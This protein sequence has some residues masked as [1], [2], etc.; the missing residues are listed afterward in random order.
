[1]A[2]NA[3][4]PR[5]ILN[6]FEPWEFPSTTAAPRTFE[7][8]FMGLESNTG[9]WMVNIGGATAAHPAHFTDY[10]INRY[11]LEERF[12]QRPLLAIARDA[13]A[14]YSEATIQGHLW[15]NPHF[16]LTGT[17]AADSCVTF[18]DGGGITLTTTTTANDQCIV[19]P[20]AQAASTTQSAWAAAKFNTLD[21]PTFETIIK[22][23]AAVTQ[24]TLAMGFKLTSTPTL[25]TDNDQAIFHV[26]GTTTAGSMTYCSSN[27]GTD[28]QVTAPTI[29]QQGST[30]LSPG[31]TVSTV[32]RPIIR[33]DLNRYPH[34]YLNGYYLGRGAQLA[35][36]VDLIPFISLQTL[37]TAARSVTIR[38]LRCSKLYND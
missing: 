1:M 19:G 18:A 11:M 23:G 21:Q 32:Y 26:T 35:S 2:G 30:R 34:F 25:A 9:R 28:T 15:S 14:A 37:T 38:G 22:T 29:V 16:A 5:N 13:A 31:L 10:W 12:S 27:A 33:V 4:F 17:N 36:D 3:K 20:V 7:P 24:M 6:I 8:G